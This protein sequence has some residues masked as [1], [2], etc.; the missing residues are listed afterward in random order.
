MP[1]TSQIVKN[2]AEEIRGEEVGKNW[3]AG[4]CRRHKLR[5]KSAYL[6]NLD[7]L[8]VS[9]ERVPL[10]VLFFIIVICFE[11]FNFFIY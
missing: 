11:S 1:P 8:R 3:V 7:N 5:L 6:R 2:L 10:F 4:F 9:V